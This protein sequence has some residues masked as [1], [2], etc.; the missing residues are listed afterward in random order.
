V[1]EDEEGFGTDKEDDERE[2]K[3]EG[4]VGGK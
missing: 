3:E 4:V 2:A 1:G